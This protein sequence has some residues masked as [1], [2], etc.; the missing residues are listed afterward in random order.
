MLWIADISKDIAQIISDLN[1]KIIA[2]DINQ[3]NNFSLGDI[4]SRTVSLKNK[5]DLQESKMLL[6]AQSNKKIR[7]LFLMAVFLFQPLSCQV[8][9]KAVLRR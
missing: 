7:F 4:K 3:T 9:S 2:I 8:A 6:E 1:S 5:I